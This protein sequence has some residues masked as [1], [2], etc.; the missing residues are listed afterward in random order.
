[1]NLGVPIRAKT[2]SVIGVLR[3]T[4]DISIMV[5]TLEDI[6]VGDSAVTL[7]DKSG[8]ILY[9]HNPALVMQPAPEN[10][11]ALLDEGVSGWSKTT[12]MD[13]EASILA[14]STLNGEEEKNLGWHLVTN[15]KMTEL[16]QYE[17]RSL[18]VGLVTALFA[19]TIGIFIT[20]LIINNSIAV[21]LNI[22]T[23]MAQSLAVGDL[24]RDMSDTEKDKV[25]NRKDE[26]GMIGK[27][28][29]R[30]IDYM[31]GMGAAA[32]AIA[33][34]DLTTSVT[35]KSEKD[36]LGNTFA[37][38]VGGLRDT[39]GQVAESANAVSASASQLASASEQSG[40][41][42]TDRHDHSTSGDG[43]YSANYRGDQDLRFGRTN[44]PRH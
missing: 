13:G 30:L 12:D 38:M 10:V 14:Y 26:I 25:R 23:K 27:A 28:F 17:L 39:V 32:S 43:Y 6:K 33:N 2:Q 18:M 44:E 16:Y 20:A 4:L 5:R 8:I 22:V 34:N 1:M 29:D 9:S 31:Q 7:I 24:V 41:Q 36:E 40:C 15:H 19:I 42:P 21:P 37:R 35:P 11:Q 3:G